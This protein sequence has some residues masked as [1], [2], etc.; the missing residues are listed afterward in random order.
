MMSGQQIV[1]YR[2]YLRC[3]L[4]FRQ[5]GTAVDEVEELLGGTGLGG[6]GAGA[7]AAVL[8]A[9][10]LPGVF[11]DLRPQLWPEHKVASLYLCRPAAPSLMNRVIEEPCSAAAARWGRSRLSR[12][13]GSTATHV[14]GR[15][16]TRV[17]RAS[18]GGVGALAVAVTA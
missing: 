8:Y 7:E 6:V 4:V 1:Q 9:E 5:V 14:A 16:V 13:S 3:A 2:V 17:R 15:R 18:D 10:T 12:E 11:A